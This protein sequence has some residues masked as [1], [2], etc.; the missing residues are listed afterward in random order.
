MNIENDAHT[1]FKNP[2]SKT[3]GEKTNNTEY[4]K[5]QSIWPSC[6]CRRFRRTRPQLLRECDVEILETIFSH[7]A[8]PGQLNQPL[9]GSPSNTSLPSSRIT[10]IVTTSA[11]LKPGCE[12]SF[13]RPTTKVYVSI[14]VTRLCHSRDGR[15]RRR[16]RLSLKLES[17]R[18]DGWTNG[19]RHLWHFCD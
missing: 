8:S 13:V 11:S 19:R 1:D 4:K 15:R 5:R 12:E 16:R 2:S 3:V 9:L 6:S 14:G 7:S 10:N 18:L 17:L